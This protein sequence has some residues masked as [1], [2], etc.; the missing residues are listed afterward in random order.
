MTTAVVAPA[1]KTNIALWVLRVLLAAMF[2]F[3]AFAKLTGNAMMVDEFATIGL[4]QWFRIFT[5]LVEIVGA[6]ALLTPAV[7]GFGAIVLL[8]VDV[9]AFVAQVGVLHMDW[10]HTIV[11]GALLAIAIYLQRGAIQS[12][13]GL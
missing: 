5:G 9:G 13:L 7:S 8:A 1:G 6:V 10:I 3:A 4:G 12:R 2:L 11:I